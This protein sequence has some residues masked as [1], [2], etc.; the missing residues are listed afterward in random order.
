VL[1]I[2]LEE[3][4]DETKDCDS[5]VADSTISTAAPISVKVACRILI[6]KVSLFARTLC[7]SGKFLRL[8]CNGFELLVCIGVV[9]RSTP[10]A[11]VH[12]QIL[13]PL[14]KKDVGTA[15]IHS[16]AGRVGRYKNGHISSAES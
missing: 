12:P 13:C 8:F 4:F 10:I 2:R 6:S 11:S 15:R 14:S 1:P 5:A 9:I 7:N 16:D 3:D